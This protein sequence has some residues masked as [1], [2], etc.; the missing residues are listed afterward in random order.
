MDSAPCHTYICIKSLPLRMQ[1]GKCRPQRRVNILGN[2]IQPARQ[3]RSTL[4]SKSDRIA[5]LSNSSREIPRDGYAVNQ[6]QT[7][8][9]ECGYLQRNDKL[10]RFFADA[11]VH[12][13]AR[14]SQREEFNYD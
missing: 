6:S 13:R 11:T 9:F 12:M 14:V 2:R 8:A 4:A 5:C 7:I 3:T 10:Q 1:A